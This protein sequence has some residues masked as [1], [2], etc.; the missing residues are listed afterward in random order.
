EVSGSSIGRSYDQIRQ[1]GVLGPVTAVQEQQS[2]MAVLQSVIDW[3]VA[4]G[5]IAKNSEGYSAETIEKVSAAMQKMA[6][7]ML[8]SLKQVMAALPTR[9]DLAL[10]ELTK[11][12]GEEYAHLFEKK[13]LQR[14]MGY[15]LVKK[16]PLDLYMSGELNSAWQSLDPA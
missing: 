14:R 5:V 10:A 7:S 12:Y 15:D 13:F 8:E 9:R 4:N 16:S 11:V 2:Q 3:G 1:R 6:E